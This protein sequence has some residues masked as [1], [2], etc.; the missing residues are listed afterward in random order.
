M[1]RY[2]LDT[3]HLTLL[4]RNHPNVLVRVQR[5]PPEQIFTT[6]ISIEE[7]IRGRLTVISQLSNQSE[8]LSRAYDYLFESLLDFNQFNVLRFDPTAA[9]YFQTL[10]QQKVRIGS[11]DLRI[12]SIALSQNAVL[13]TRNYRDFIQVPGLHLEDWTIQRET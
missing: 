6:I 12:A 5:I 4:K 9:Q 3:D 7:Q 10:R 1:T 2:I 11:Q 8:K 13:V